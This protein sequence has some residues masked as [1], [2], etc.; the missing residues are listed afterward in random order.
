MTSL[1]RPR[2]NEPASEMLASQIFRLLRYLVTASFC[3]ETLYV[4]RA[5]FRIIAKPRRIPSFPAWV[6]IAGQIHMIPIRVF[7][8]I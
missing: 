1:L 5:L 2:N 4:F 6:A 7:V 8:A 3:A